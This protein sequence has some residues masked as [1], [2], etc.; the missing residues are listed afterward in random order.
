MM[1]MKK[2]KS[3]MFKPLYEVFICYG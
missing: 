1:S 2:Y 3:D